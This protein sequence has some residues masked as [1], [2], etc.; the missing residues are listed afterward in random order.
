M[1]YTHKI[2]KI[3]SVSFR[4]TSL[5]FLFS[6]EFILKARA[7]HLKDIS[8]I[9]GEEVI[10]KRFVNSLYLMFAFKPRVR[11]LNNCLILPKSL[12]LKSIWKLFVSLSVNLRKC[13]P[14]SHSLLKCFWIIWKPFKVKNLRNV[15]RCSRNR[16]WNV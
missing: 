12:N 7:I 10:N 15:T 2:L 11:I 13:S 4:S 14:L 6:M 16:C 1:K 5:K 9:R 3:A 8:W